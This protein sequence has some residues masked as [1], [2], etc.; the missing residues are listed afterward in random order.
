MCSARLF[1]VGPALLMCLASGCVRPASAPIPDNLHPG[2]L[3]A[4]ATCTRLVRLVPVGLQLGSEVSIRLGPTSNCLEIRSGVKEP[5]QLLR[6]P[7]SVSAYYVTVH[8]GLRRA[9][10]V[11][12]IELLGGK[13]KV[14]RTLTVKDMKSVGNGLSATFFVTPD[15]P[16]A[17]YILVYPDPALTGDSHEHLNQGMGIGYYGL[18]SLAYGTSSQTSITYVERGTLE[19]STAPYRAPEVK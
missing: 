15:R 10:L 8:T 9:T 7:R 2:Y 12:R 17:R 4:G 11:P 13:R 6:L 19:I 14:L 5:V 3:L 18:Y 1:A 16:E